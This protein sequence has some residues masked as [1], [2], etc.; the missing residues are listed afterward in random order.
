MSSPP[1]ANL[2]INIPRLN[3]PALYF[4]EVS[5]FIEW[6][7]FSNV[8]DLIIHYPLDKEMLIYIVMH[9]CLE[10]CLV[11]DKI[12]RNFTTLASFRLSMNIN[13]HERMKRILLILV[14]AFL[15]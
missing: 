1:I 11:E 15:S 10:R 2:N 4:V 12:I 9:R 14:V 8:R 7:F 3:A 13:D 5:F 6:R